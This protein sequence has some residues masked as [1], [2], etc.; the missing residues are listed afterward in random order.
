MTKLLVGASGSA[1]V[2]G[3]PAYLTALRDDLGATV[4]VVMTHSARLFLPEQTVGLHADRVVT[5][6]DPTRWP[7][8]NQAALALSHDAILI[9]PATANMI[10]AA[11]TGA[12]PNLLA[13]VI[14][15]ATA[16]VVF[17]PM[18][19]PTM[20]AKPVVGRNL[21]RLRQD[22]HRVVGPAVDGPVPALPPPAEVVAAT[23][24]ALG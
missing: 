24:E 18:M 4:T 17:F 1:S 6:D 8:D 11:A 3:L 13:G 22:G 5:G 7:T 16:P 14:L 10:S 15:A 12:A 9:L 20:L 19:S 2:A 23:K 21:E